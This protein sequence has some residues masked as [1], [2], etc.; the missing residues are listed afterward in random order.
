MI[1]SRLRTVRALGLLG[2][3]C[4][5]LLL[6][7]CRPALSDIVA[8]QSLFAE[9]ELFY[10][11]NVDSTFVTAVFRAGRQQGIAVAL[12]GGSTA[13]VNGDLL[14]QKQGNALR[15]VYYTRAYD[16]LV[17]NATF[18]WWDL[19]QRQYN[20]TIRLPYIAFP[21]GLEAIG[22]DEGTAIVWGGD[23]LALYETAILT[24][25]ADSLPR[26]VRVQEDDLLA[27][28]IAIAPQVFDDLSAATLRLQLERHLEPP[29]A[30]TTAAGGRLLSRFRTRDRLVRLD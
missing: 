26:S 29:M 25:N 20:N 9:F 8:Q 17:Y 7:A 4:W 2:L 14:L 13:T 12:A 22:R 11:A 21:D 24:L 1:P 23:P 28:A 10:D 18:T 16:G 30:E 27:R 19:D 5:G 6:D 15:E 3:L